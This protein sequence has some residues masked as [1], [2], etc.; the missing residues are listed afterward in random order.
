[1]FEF[2][3]QADAADVLGATAYAIRMVTQL[4]GVR[5]APEMLALPDA[6]SVRQR[7]LGERTVAGIETAEGESIRQLE[8]GQV[9]GHVADLYARVEKLWASSTESTAEARR[10]LTRFRTGTLG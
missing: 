8:S 5:G 3:D 1:M 9:R 2:P 7:R 6:F 4:G 10:I